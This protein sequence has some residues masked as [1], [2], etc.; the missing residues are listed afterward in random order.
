M[1]LRLLD[2]AIAAP[3]AFERSQFSHLRAG[4][5]FNGAG[6]ARM[7]FW[8]PLRRKVIDVVCG[9]GTARELPL[10]AHEALHVM[11][12]TS[13]FVVVDGTGRAT[14]VYPGLIQLTS[15]FELQEVRSLDD[16]PFSMNVMLIRAPLV[17]P[18]GEMAAGNQ[19]EES[20]GFAQR[21]VCDPGLD[22]ELRA[23][24]DALR[25]PLVALDCE[26]RLLDCVA[27]LVA[28][29]VARHAERRRGPER[30]T[31]TGSGI[32]RARDYLC[33]HVADPVALDELAGVAGL[34]KFYLLRA[35]HRAYGLT[36]HAYQMQLRLARA[37]RLL[38]EGRP[39]SHVTYDAGFAD[40]SHL[41]RRF[42]SFFGFTPAQYAR[43]F[44]APSSTAP[45]EASGAIAS[46]AP[47]PAA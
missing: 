11:L 41:T 16:A 37:R 4:E 40:Q 2:S 26:S 17:A 7:R 30:G 13:R 38:A 31:R 1:Q 28:R 8:R 34:S 27:R 3:A 32:A 6:A 45:R 39:L 19:R 23:L 15:P 36:P 33:A 43:Q 20:P 21:V 42:K 14:T 5:P 10:H 35:F 47:L 25:R 12:P 29:L 46:A 24:F 44:T 9:E 22:S 18:L